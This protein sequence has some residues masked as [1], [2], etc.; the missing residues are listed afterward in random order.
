MKWLLTNLLK[1]GAHFCRAHNLSVNLRN[2]K[3]MH[4]NL[5][6]VQLTNNDLALH[7]YIGIEELLDSQQETH[8][9]HHLNPTPHKVVACVE[10]HQF[11]LGRRQQIKPL[12]LN[13]A[14]HWCT[15]WLECK[16]PIEVHK[17][18]P[19]LHLVW[20]KQVKTGSYSAVERKK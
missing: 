8:I 10:K 2:G 19:C 14:R 17:L 9:Q 15:L 7:H 3:T 1:D 16:Y 18:F 20:P 11:S 13:I 12:K 5:S 6:V 4:F